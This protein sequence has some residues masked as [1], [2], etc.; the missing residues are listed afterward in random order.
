MFNLSE[1]IAQIPINVYV[2]VGC[3][4]VGWLMKKF[5]PTDNKIIPLV[6]VT[7]GAIVYVL[8]EEVSVENIIIG[9][10]TGAAS[11]GLHQV[12]KQYVEGKDLAITNGDG[13]KA[14]DFEADPVESI[15]PRKL[16]SS[17]TVW[18]MAVAR[19]P[20]TP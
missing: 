5:L 15:Q 1:I 9:A 8:L 16:R 12:F 14:E 2:L 17:I 4:V 20:F 6:M 7:L 10:F 11:T 19:W 18:I 13:S 3:L